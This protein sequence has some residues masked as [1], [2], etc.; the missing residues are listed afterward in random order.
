LI[1]YMDEKFAELAFELP[2]TEKPTQ[3]GGLR[4]G[5]YNVVGVVTDFVFP[6]KTK[7]SDLIF[8]FYISDSSVAQGSKG[9]Q[10]ILFACDISLFPPIK[11]IGDIVY[12]H[13]LKV[14]RYDREGVLQGKKTEGARGTSIAVFS[15]E[16]G[17]PCQK[18]ESPKPKMPTL[19]GPER[20]YY[21]QIIEY[22]RNSSVLSPDIA[23]EFTI[24]LETL[25]TEQYLD[26]FCRIEHLERES[27]ANGVF[28]FY[29][30]DGTMIPPIPGCSYQNQHDK[31]FLEVR[32]FCAPEVA[33]YLELDSAIWVKLRSF[34]SKLDNGRVYLQ[35]HIKSSITR[36]ADHHP[37][38]KQILENSLFPRLDG[39]TLLF[40]KTS[41]YHNNSTELSP[42][43]PKAPEYKLSGSS[44]LT[45]L[46]PRVIS[47]CSHTSKPL[48]T[49]K[50]ILEYKK[51]PARFR[52]KVQVDSF[53]PR[54]VQKLT[55]PICICC[56]SIMNRNEQE[57]CCSKCNGKAAR[58]S[59]MFTIKVKDRTGSLELIVFDQQGEKFFYNL[60]ATN[61][62]ENNCSFQSIKRKMELICRKT[63]ILDCCV[64]SYQPKLPGKSSVRYQ[65]FDTT[66]I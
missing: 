43:A 5:V 11:A 35:N 45:S 12:I 40:H 47:K 55:Q 41:Y 22:L 27:E 21:P 14:F 42:H 37:A 29:V 38:T 1:A 48:S 25:K 32:Y 26:I 10:I 44:T 46:K 59:Y 28:K 3:I 63:S 52:C 19:K 9:I 65:I 8:R 51:V 56:T 39:D 62:E 6:T 33:K 58:Y 66:V 61:L 50:E 16:P 53:R 31:C 60:P 54:N 20:R 15:G 49:I 24:T 36:I 23:N 17:A 64:L 18:R 7:G 4:P 2:F 13:N 34:N 30:W 57:I